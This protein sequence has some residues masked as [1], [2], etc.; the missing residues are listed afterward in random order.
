MM[1]WT[2]KHK[3]KRIEG[4]V[5]Q[6]KAIIEAYD[7]LNKWKPGQA[8]MFHGPVGVGKTLLAEIAAAERD[9]ALVRV[10][11]SES[12]SGKD[13]EGL[14]AQSS[15]QQT[16]FHKGKLILVDEVDG[17][18]G[19]ERGAGA[20]ML[21]IIRESR[22]PMILVANDPWKPKLRSLRQHCRLVKFNR[23][24]YP[25][26]AKRLKEIARL[27]GKI[28]E[29]GV[30]KDLARWA[31][32]D[33]RSALIDLQLLSAG[34]DKVTEHDLESL[35][36]RERERTILYVLPTI[37]YSGSLRASRKVIREIDK[38]PDEVFW[39]LESNLEAAYKDRRSLAD[40][41]ELL[42]KA[43]MFRSLVS[44][45][46][47]WRFKAYMVDMMSGI[48]LF[49]DD[50]HGFVPFRPPYR[51]L[52]LGQ[53]KHRRALMKSLSTKLGE[54]LHVSGKVVIRDYLPFMRYM[55]KGWEM[56]PEIGLTDEEMD[57]IKQY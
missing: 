3:P 30:L 16:L 13:L 18:T 22:F 31:S 26:I 36:F 11:A 47:N 48:S 33:M 4:M 50:H 14:L 21:K 51:L 46:Q 20:S 28:L 23:I 17:I 25:S 32:G 6:R 53:T 24:P 41:Y 39:W 45:Q 2:D 5:G 15:R 43:D 9:W 7:F 12:R 27:E 29:G 40:G 57:A 10:N 35:G 42:A 52:R 37:F 44:R 34:K 8:L 54:Y 49:K 1:L 38:D 19:S 55:K 56:P